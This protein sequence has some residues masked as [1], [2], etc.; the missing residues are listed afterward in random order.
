MKPINIPGATILGAPPGWDADKH[1]PCAGLPV[2]ILDG[3]FYSF[4]KPTWRDLWALARGA[5]I[6]LAVVGGQPPVDLS[7][8]RGVL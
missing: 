1:G 2:V 8:V 4:W 6:Q 3:V 5:V 7:V